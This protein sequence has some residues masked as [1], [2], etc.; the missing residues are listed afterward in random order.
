M[1]HELFN[2]KEEKAWIPATT[3][4][5]LANA[6]QVNECNRTTQIECDSIYAKVKG[7]SVVA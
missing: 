2:H 7:R 3:R 4:T 6:M 5:N 1:E